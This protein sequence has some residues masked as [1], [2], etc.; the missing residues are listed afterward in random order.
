MPDINNFEQWKNFLS[1]QLNE[2]KEK[3]VSE[4]IVSD[5]AVNIGDYLSKEVEPD[6]PENQLLSALWSVATSE[7]KHAIANTMVKLVQR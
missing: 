5:I 2:A 7:E 1:E 3:G 4:N 6:I